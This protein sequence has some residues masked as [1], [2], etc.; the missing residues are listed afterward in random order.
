MSGCL[1]QHPGGW[2][3]ATNRI[4]KYKSCL[5]MEVKVLVNGRAN[6]TLCQTVTIGCGQMPPAQPGWCGHRLHHLSSSGLMQPNF[7]SG[8][9][10]EMERAEQRDQ[11]CL[12][13]HEQH[14]GASQVNPGLSR[15]AKHRRESR[16]GHPFWHV[17]DS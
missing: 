2:A 12:V 17:W 4:T 14:S 15:A 8:C 6:E 9:G 11:H 1:N 10:T 3:L 7:L 13:L 16:A 5:W